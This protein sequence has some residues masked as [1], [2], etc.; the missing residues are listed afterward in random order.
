VIDSAG[1]ALA[2]QRQ[3]IVR[4]AAAVVVHPDGRVLLA[5]RPPGKHYAGYWEFP[6]GKLE[7]GEAPAD[8]LAREL[9]EEIGLSDALIRIS[10]GIENVEDL[11]SDLAQGLEY[12]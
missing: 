8:A 11:I 7:A 2:A 3:R 5:Q 10:I 4:V 1:N 6:G 12:V 9:R